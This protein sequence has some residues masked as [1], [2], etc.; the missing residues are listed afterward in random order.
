VER[1][2]ELLGM[3]ADALR[4]RCRR[5]ARKVGR[6]VVATLGL[7]ILGIKLGRSWRIQ[8]PTGEPRASLAL[9]SARSGAIGG[10]DGS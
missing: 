1:A 5:A 10:S 6:D 9:G 3:T 2:A 7:G 8:F 4:A